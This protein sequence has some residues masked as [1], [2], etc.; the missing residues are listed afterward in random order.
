MTGKRAAAGNKE[1]NANVQLEVCTKCFLG[2]Q[3]AVLIY[4]L[5]QTSGKSSV[6]KCLEELLLV[7][8]RSFALFTSAD[9]GLGLRVV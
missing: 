4:L 5:K 7:Q 6:G 3:R 9:Y 1:E 8:Q 2:T